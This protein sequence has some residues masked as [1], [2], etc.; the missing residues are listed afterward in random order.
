MGMSMLTLG[1]TDIKRAQNQN[2]S[3]AIL[4]SWREEK[5]DKYLYVVNI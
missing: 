3:L 1:Q 2:Y 4:G 5:K